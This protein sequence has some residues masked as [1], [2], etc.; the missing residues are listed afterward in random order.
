MHQEEQTTHTFFRE[1]YIVQT[2]FFI[3]SMRQM[4][5]GRTKRLNNSIDMIIRNLTEIAGQSYS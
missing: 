2:D 3:A 4:A 1:I 5:V